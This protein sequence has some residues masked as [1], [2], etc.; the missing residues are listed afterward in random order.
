MAN[1]FVQGDCFVKI[2]FLESR[3]IVGGLSSVWRF[4]R[5]DI[6]NSTT[7]SKLTGYTEVSFL[8]SDAQNGN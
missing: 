4:G 1:S 3:N 2:G 6:H 5:P 7:T 8:Y